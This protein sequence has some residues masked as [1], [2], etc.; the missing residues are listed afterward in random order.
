LS[1]LTL[2][3][4]STSA[5]RWITGISSPQMVRRTVRV[6]RLS[7]VLANSPFSLSRFLMVISLTASGSPVQR[8]TSWAVL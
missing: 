1:E 3:T 6:P 8:P 4:D 7:S 5:R 2:E